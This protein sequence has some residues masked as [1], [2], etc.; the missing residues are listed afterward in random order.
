MKP[1]EISRK[2]LIIFRL[3]SFGSAKSHRKFHR[4]EQKKLNESR[5]K[6]KETSIEG[7]NTRTEQVSEKV[8]SCS[9]LIIRLTVMGGK[10]TASHS[11]IDTIQVEDSCNEARKYEI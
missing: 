1:N 3:K 11:V 10:Q 8:E 9:C 6:Q 5:L 4:K 7:I 2:H